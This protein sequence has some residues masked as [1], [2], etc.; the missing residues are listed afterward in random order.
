MTCF[1]HGLNF[2]R[3]G[4]DNKVVCLLLIKGLLDIFLSSTNRIFLIFSPLYDDTWELLWKK[5]DWDYDLFW[6]RK[7]GLVLGVGSW[8][9]LSEESRLRCV[10][11]PFVWRSLTRLVSLSCLRGWGRTG[12]IGTESGGNSFTSIFVVILA[13]VNVRKRIDSANLCGI[14]SV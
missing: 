7:F 1:V 9:F 8:Q 6:A 2:L 12:D 3:E 4:L 5:K 14:E 13:F 10:K 11:K